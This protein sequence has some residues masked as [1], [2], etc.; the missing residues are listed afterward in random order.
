MEPRDGNKLVQDIA[1]NI[2]DL[3]KAK[4]NAVQAIVTEAEAIV[5]ERMNKEAPLDYVYYMS[6]LP[7][8]RPIYFP[9]AVV[10]NKTITRSSHFGNMQINTN[11][12]SVHVPTDVSDWG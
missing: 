1:A 3:L 12:S 5:A 7:E 9:N 8:P 6:K 11:Y 4:K 10:P 2:Y